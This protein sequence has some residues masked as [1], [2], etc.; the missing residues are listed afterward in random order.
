MNGQLG[1]KFKAA[2]KNRDNGMLGNILTD[3][4]HILPRKRYSACIYYQPSMPSFDNSVDSNQQP[5]FFLSLNQSE[6]IFN[7]HRGINDFVYLLSFQSA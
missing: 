2:A 1:P 5:V 7:M 3:P 4:I 6:F